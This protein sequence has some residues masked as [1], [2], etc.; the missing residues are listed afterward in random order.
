MR[1]RDLFGVAVRVIGFWFLTQAVYYGFWAFV[2]TNSGLGNPTISPRE[3][4]AL[5][6]IYLI[7]GA[8]IMFC[9]D[10]IVWLV[11]GIPMKTTPPDAA[12]I[13]LTDAVSDEPP[14][15]E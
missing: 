4:V 15:P 6:A 7:M 1:P 9:A 14:P 13:P 5:S 10:P 2:K 12:N 11:Y 8:L 3:D